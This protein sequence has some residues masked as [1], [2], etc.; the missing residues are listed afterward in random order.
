[1]TFKS[2]TDRRR[3]L[4]QM[5]A[6]S[7]LTEGPVGSPQAKAAAKEYAD[8][9]T[10]RFR[11]HIE[12]A[13][14]AIL[15]E[16]KPTPAQLERGLELHRESMVCDLYGG[17]NPVHVTG[18]YS[19]SMKAWA[20]EV[21]DREPDPERKQELFRSTVRPQIQKWRA[22]EVVH[23]PGFRANHRLAWET[24]QIDLGLADVAWA[25]EGEG[26]RG[27]LEYLASEAYA[28]DHLD[29]LEKFLRI[30]DLQGFKQ[31]GKHAVI[32]HLGRPDACF[33]GPHIKDPIRSLDLYYGFGVRHC[34]L[35]N[36][37][38]NQLGTSHY[39]EVDTGLT[40]MGEAVIRRM[41][42]LGIMVDLSHSGTRTTLD[43]IRASQEP[44]LIS[45]TACRALSRGGKSPNRNATDEAIRSVAERGGMIGIITVPNLLGGF[46]AETVYRHLDH[47]VKLV[48]V[49]HVGLASDQGPMGRAVQAPEIVK[50]LKP[51]KFLATGFKGTRAYW[52]W[53]TGPR[54]LS[55]VNAPYLT[56]G[57]VVRGY[58][59]DDIRKIIGGN[60]L[61]VAGTILDKQPRGRLT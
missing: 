35:T 45:H 18:F 16:L 58:S 44:V 4:V 37:T 28:F 24:A 10:Q 3:F 25:P 6:L 7:L 57:L 23:D 59:D 61:R 53:E 48:G 54:P 22:L 46:G 17:S 21:L 51:R 47:A 19:E 20:L 12:G 1:M 55:W 34:Q 38:R 13:R 60:F 41:N 11:K 5:G 33:A 2:A 50:I 43:A 30:E 15:E 36:S 52:E 8:L 42:Q 27:S 40:E 32:W 31:A 29:Y 49:D 26:D 9:A 56:V 14:K 39:Q